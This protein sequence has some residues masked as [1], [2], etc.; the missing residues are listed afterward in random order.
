M[1]AVASAVAVPYLWLRS[2]GNINGHSPLV[3]VATYAFL[4]AGP[5]VVADWALK[6]HA[7]AA[8]V[9]KMNF[10]LNFP[11]ICNFYSS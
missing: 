8:K 9:K 1:L 4:F 7:L 2:C 5:A 3:V 6:G 10:S 11:Y